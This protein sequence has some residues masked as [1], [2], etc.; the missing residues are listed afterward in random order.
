MRQGR[1]L[2]T[3]NPQVEF[4]KRRAKRIRVALFNGSTGQFIV[5]HCGGKNLLGRIRDGCPRASG[6][7]EMIRL[8]A[9]KLRVDLS[10]GAASCS[11]HW[12]RGHSG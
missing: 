1:D 2:I 3:K 8:I 12:Q 5:N 9:G 7:S 11:E 10:I 4:P 6:K